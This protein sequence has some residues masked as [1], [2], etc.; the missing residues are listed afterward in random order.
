MLVHYQPAAETSREHWINAFTT[1]V[2]ADIFRERCRK[3]RKDCVHQL[4]KRSLRA[5]NEKI[6]LYVVK[7]TRLNIDE[8]TA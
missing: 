6:T 1:R 7:S 5:Y 3:H 4:T 8:E 2:D